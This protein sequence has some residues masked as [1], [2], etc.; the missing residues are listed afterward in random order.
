MKDVI[1]YHYAPIIGEVSKYVNKQLIKPQDWAEYHDIKGEFFEKQF[2][3]KIKIK[4]S[5][6]YGHELFH[7]HS[8]LVN[9]YEEI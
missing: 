6:E 5:I 1:E 9:I 3:E 8:G 7:G 2:K 4:S